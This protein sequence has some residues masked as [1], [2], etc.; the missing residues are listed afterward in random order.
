MPAGIAVVERGGQ[1]L[2]KFLLDF[3]FP[4]TLT[5]EA[6]FSRCGLFL[7]LC[8]LEVLVA[9]FSGT[10]PRAVQKTRGNCRELTMWSFLQS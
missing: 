5:R 7:N 3:P 6:D 1:P 4:S 10:H 9:D 8:L 2:I